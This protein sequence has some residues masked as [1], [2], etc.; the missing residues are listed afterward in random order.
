L[1]LLDLL[2]H[3]DQEESEDGM[4]LRDPLDCAVL[5]EH[6]DLLVSREALA[7][8]AHLAFPELQVPRETWE[9]PETKAALVYRVHEENQ[10]SL[11]CL[12]SLEKWDPLERTA[13]TEK[14]EDRDRLVPLD[15]QV[16]QDRGVS[17]D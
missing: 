5:M 3:L 12:G 17:L 10:A 6:L 9:P 16:S 2:D 11:V 13:A 1:D 14:K 4:D 8:L 7:S 15:R